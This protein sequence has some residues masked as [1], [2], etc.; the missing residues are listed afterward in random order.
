MAQTPAPLSRQNTLGRRF[1]ETPIDQTIESL[2]NPLT[3]VGLHERQLAPPPAAQDIL[4]LLQGV[5]L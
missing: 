4:Q 5:I 3:L 2:R 1:A